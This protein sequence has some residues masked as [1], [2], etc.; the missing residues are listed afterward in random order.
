MQETPA[1][2][3]FTPTRRRGPVT[4]LTTTLDYEPP[5]SP[6]PPPPPPVI[7]DAPFFAILDAPLLAGET[8]AAGFDRKERE[9]AAAFAQLPVLAARGLHMRL[10]NPRSGDSLVDKFSRLTIERRTRLLNFLADARRR[11]VLG[12]K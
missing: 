12:G 7:D 9:L 4:S 8:A 10:A 3:L 2:P 6:P 1:A 11:A 5:P